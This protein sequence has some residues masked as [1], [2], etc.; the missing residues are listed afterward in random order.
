MEEIFELTNG[1]ESLHEISNDNGLRVLNI[2][3]SKNLAVK[4]AQKLP[5]HNIHNFSRTS[6]HEKTHDMIDHILTER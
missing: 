5:H 2:A 6:P 4:S 3:T 1:I